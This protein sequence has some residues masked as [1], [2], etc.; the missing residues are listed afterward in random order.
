MRAVDNLV[1]KVEKSWKS[2]KFDQSNCVFGLFAKEPIAGRVK[3]RLT[4]VLSPLQACELY[5]TSLFE[6]VRRFSS[7]NMPFAVFYDGDH[8]WFKRAF[9]E[10][11]LYPQ[12]GEDLGTRLSAALNTLSDTSDGFAAI[13]GTDSPD[14]PLSLLKQAVTGLVSHDVVAIPCADGGFAAI[15]AREAF[16]DLFLNIPWSTTTVLEALRKRCHELQLRFDTTDS[17]YDLD[18][19]DDLKTLVKRSPGTKTAGYISEHLKEIF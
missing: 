18:E 6:T 3:T 17:W 16:P 10:C 19:I 2:K 14:L 8:K 11:D 4:P 5:K 13:V 15:G 1:D 9:P 7:F 12:K